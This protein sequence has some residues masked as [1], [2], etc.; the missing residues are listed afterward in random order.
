MSQSGVGLLV[1][2]DRA[3]VDCGYN[4]RGL[5]VDGRCPECNALIRHSLHGCRLRFANPRWLSRVRVG[6]YLKLG[7]VG[8]AAVGTLVSGL[9]TSQRV[10]PTVDGATIL[11]TQI[12]LL[13]GLFA[14]TTQE[15]REA[16]MERT[17]CVRK[18]ARMC[19]ASAFV[20]VLFHRVA[21]G[22]VSPTFTASALTPFHLVGILALC[23]E[24]VYWR[25][26]ATRVPN[27]TLEKCTTG[28][29]WLVVLFGGITTVT[30]TIGLLG[31]GANVGVG[32]GRAGDLT[33][34]AGYYS[35]YRG[36]QLARRILLP[37]FG[38]WY[39]M[40]VFVYKKKL[41]E[42]VAKSH[43]WRRRVEIQENG[44]QSPV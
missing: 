14:L 39:I 43:A 24:L 26:L 3:C 15:P 11:I 42:A 23:C 10:S 30:A 13:L 29:L 37:I 2:T 7:S 41:N 35:L 27:A 1:V 36:T 25:R 16:Q 33:L 38:I 6:A 28:L 5:K 32:V 40:M 12:L 21:G 9:I 4:L 44:G 34:G 8:V 22:T 18:V 20:G 17:F 19:A 31:A